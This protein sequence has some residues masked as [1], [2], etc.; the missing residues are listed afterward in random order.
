[1]FQ[2]YIIQVE[3]RTQFICL[4][5]PR[6]A[7]RLSTRRWKDEGGEKSPRSYNWF[8]PPSSDSFTFTKAAQSSVKCK[9]LFIPPAVRRSCKVSSNT[10]KI[11]SCSP[12]FAY[13]SS[14]SPRLFPRRLPQP[15]KQICSVFHQTL[16]WFSAQALLNNDRNASSQ[17]VFKLNNWWISMALCFSRVGSFVMFEYLEARQWFRR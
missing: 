8:S 15:S 4:R 14:L 9:D 10:R 6:N 2:I 17:N 11:V 13:S 16:V 3:S 1:M 12:F 7:A 5:C